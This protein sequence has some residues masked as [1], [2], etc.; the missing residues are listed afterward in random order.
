V[1]LTEQLQRQAVMHGIADAVNGVTR[2][3]T[4]SA[5]YDEQYW[6]DY[7]AG[8]AAWHESERE[9]PTADSPDEPEAG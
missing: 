9:R 6:T 7:R 3:P 2:L 4:V 5:V 8:F 1:P